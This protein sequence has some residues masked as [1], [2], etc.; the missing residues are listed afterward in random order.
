[1]ADG[2]QIG[3]DWWKLFNDPQLNALEQQA[4]ALSPTLAIASARVERA[5]AQSSVVAA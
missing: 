5:R 4:L 1:V 3:S 2:L